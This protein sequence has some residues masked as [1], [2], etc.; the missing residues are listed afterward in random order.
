MKSLSLVLASAFLLPSSSWA[1]STWDNVGPYGGWIHDLVEDGNGRIL[2]A[3]SFGGIYRTSD[4]AESWQQIFNQPLFIDPRAI[5]TNASGHIFVG[6]DGFEG[7]GFL[8]STDDGTTWQVV[9][10]ALSSSLVRDLLVTA[11]QEIYACT[12][13]EGL[14]R[15]TNNGTTF[16]QVASLPASSTT[17]IATNSSGHLFVGVQFESGNLYRSTDNGATWQRADTGIAADVDRIYV[18]GSSIYA[19]TGIAVYRSTDNGATWT[20]FQTPSASGVRA[21]TFDP[22]GNAY[23]SLYEG[24]ATGDGVYRSTNGGATWTE[25]TGLT[26]RAVTHLLSTAQGTVF[27][28]T[29]GVGVYGRD[30]GAIA[31]GVD[32]VQKVN[33]MFNTWITSIAEDR[34]TGDLYAATLESG[35]F[36]STDGGLTWQRATAGIPYYEFIRGL[37]VSI[38]GSVFACGS[39][40]NGIYRSTDHGASWTSVHA[41]A[42]TTIACNA[43]GDVFFGIGSRVYRS[44][45]NGATWTQHNLPG[46]VSNIAEI[47]FDG[48]TVY[49]ATGSLGGFGGQGVY[50]ST[51]NGTTWAA[52]NTGLTNLNVTTIA[53]GQTTARTAGGSCRISIG[54]DGAGIWDLDIATGTWTLNGSAGSASA[55]VAISKVLDS[56]ES[57][58]AK[59]DEL[60]DLRD[61]CEWAGVEVPLELRSDIKRLFIKLDD[62]DVNRTARAPGVVHFVGTGGHGILRLSDAPLDV[63]PDGPTPGSVLG[64]TFPNPFHRSTVVEFEIASRQLVDLRIYDAS[65]RE[66]ATLVNEVR[67]PGRYGV[68]WDASGLSSGVY[69]ARLSTAAGVETRR[70]ALLR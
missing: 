43:A 45:D 57:T 26:G 18:N 66:L 67:S 64:R 2:A 41:S 58:A 55:I 68:T 62:E 22:S 10:N 36:R 34:S 39:Y 70:L 60:L 25:D 47:A 38:N 59:L 1:Q 12:S 3:S 61:G 35:V 46:G 23:V 15:S 29:A 52:F 13:N 30:G 4:D 6:T 65:G 48:T 31:G 51:D 17:R 32:W 44:T 49:A 28:G 24:F 54:T 5:A 14:F 69:F 11:S 27:C 7:T 21:L 8:R 40:S 20:T 53:V 19:V 50:R 16:S 33:G 56:N 63:D 37:A 9:T 42:A